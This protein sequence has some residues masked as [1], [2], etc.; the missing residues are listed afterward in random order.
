M[1][2][3]LSTSFWKSFLGLFPLSL[4]LQGGFVFDSPTH[5]YTAEI[6]KGGRLNRPDTTLAQCQKRDKTH[7]HMNGHD[8]KFCLLNAQAEHSLINSDE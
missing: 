7:L 3:G 1:L 4:P 8:N 2:S 5:F 6:Q